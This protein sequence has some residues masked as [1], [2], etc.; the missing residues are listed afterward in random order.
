MGKTPEPLKIHNEG[1]DYLVE[2]LS[3]KGYDSINKNVE[4]H[5]VI[6]GEVFDG[7]IDVMATRGEWIHLYEVK[8][9]HSGGKERKAKSQ[10]KRYVRSH[11]DQKVRLIY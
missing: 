1:I 9:K 11:P 7:E 6:N 10:L 4:Y 5:L 3:T 2:R 8:Y